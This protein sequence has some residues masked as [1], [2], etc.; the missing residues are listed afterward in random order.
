MV[1][2]M[3]GQ[4]ICTVEHTATICL[5]THKL[6]VYSLALALFCH[7]WAVKCAWATNLYFNDKLGKRRA[8]TIDAAAAIL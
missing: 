6:T 3:A 8:R 5:G 2:L 7:Q 4:V 1:A